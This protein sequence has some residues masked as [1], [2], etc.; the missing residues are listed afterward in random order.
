MSPH[1]GHW[2]SD[3]IT[4]N[5]LAQRLFISAAAWAVVI[6][7]ITGIV[8][9]SIYRQA[10]ERAFDRRLGVYLRTIVADLSSPEEPSDKFPQ[11]LGEPLFELPLSGWYWQV[12][13][14][15]PDKHDVRSSR[16]LFDGGLPHLQDRGVATGIDGTRRGQ[17]TSG[18]GWWNAI[19]ISATKGIISWRSP[20]TLPRLPMKY[21]RSIRR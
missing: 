15:D 7:V 2:F 16:S 14:T 6:L 8:L 18:C 10:V 1:R 17:R 21:I 4:R 3:K 9:S 5:S 13:R 12:T 20:A 11:S 19:S